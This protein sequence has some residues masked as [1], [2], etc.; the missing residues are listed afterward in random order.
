MDIV[1]NVIDALCGIIGLLFVFFGWETTKSQYLLSLRVAA[2]EKD[3]EE[4]LSN[5]TL[6]EDL[7][8]TSNNKERIKLANASVKAGTKKKHVLDMLMGSAHNFSNLRSAQEWY[9]NEKS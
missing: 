7:S 1:F 2:E 6:L 3:K 9:A 8:R 5:F 4:K